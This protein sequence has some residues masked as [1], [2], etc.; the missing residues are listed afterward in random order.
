MD[1]YTWTISTDM[2]NV[3]MIPSIE[4]LMSIKPCDNSSIVVVAID[5]SRD[6]ALRELQTGV[7]S[8]SSNWITIKDVTDQL[9]NLVYN[10]MGYIHL[11]SIFF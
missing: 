7:L 4:S 5:K 8:L 1:A 11:P 10:R 9:A 3:G 2:Q 6:P